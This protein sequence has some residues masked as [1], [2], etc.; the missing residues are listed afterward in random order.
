MVLVSDDAEIDH[1]KLAI[2]QRT[3]I[4]IVMQNRPRWCINSWTAVPKTNCLPFVALSKMRSNL[5]TM[6]QSQLSHCLPKTSTIWS[7]ALFWNSRPLLSDAELVQ[8]VVQGTTALTAVA[9]RNALDASV[10][11]AVASTGDTDAIVTLLQNETANIEE[12]TFDRNC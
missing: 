10:S 2:R 9:R 12:T 1:E 8:I 11:D 4:L 6:C 7:P 5:W 3:S